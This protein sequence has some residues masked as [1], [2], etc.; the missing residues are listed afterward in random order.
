M[1]PPSRIP[2][3][4][5]SP[6]PDGPSGGG[7]QPPLRAIRS[8]ANPVVQR[9]RRERRDPAAYR[10]S[11]ELWLEGDHLCEAWLE[12]GLPVRQ[13][14]CSES[15]WGRWQRSGRRLPQAEVLLLPDALFESVSGLQSATGIGLIGPVPPTGALQKGVPSV[16]L[17]RLQDPGNV[18]SLLRTAAALGFRQVVALAGTVA[19]WSPKVLRAGMGAHFALSLAEGIVPQQLAELGVPLVAAGSHEALPL[20]LA[21]LPW[22]VAWLLGHE[23]QGVDPSLRTLCSLTV[24]IPQPGGQESLNVAAAGA[25]CLYESA[26]RGLAQPLA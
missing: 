20:H 7:L 15:G 13:V 16:V 17:D 8:A 1:S 12:A 10:A 9:L 19:L 26:R 5:R 18:G 25:I 14:V 3:D 22:P 2:G 24:A 6:P 21:P 11:G 4:Q 23:G